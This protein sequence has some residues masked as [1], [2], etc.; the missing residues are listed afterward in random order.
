MGSLAVLEGSEVA[1]KHGGGGLAVLLAGTVGVE[2][3]NWLFRFATELC[4]DVSI[5][6]M[7]LSSVE[8]AGG[9]GVGVGGRRCGLY[10][11]SCRYSLWKREARASFLSG[12]SFENASAELS[13]VTMFTSMRERASEMAFEVSVGL[14]GS[15]WGGLAV[16]GGCFEL[17]GDI[18]TPFRLL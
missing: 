18:L 13:I 17:E 6:F 10:T 4:S 14:G 2:E 8:M 16:L 12:Y 15:E 3:R 1:V 5:S 9:L 11:L 7:S